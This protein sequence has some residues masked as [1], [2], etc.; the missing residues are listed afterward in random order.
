MPICFLRLFHLQTFI[1]LRVQQETC[2]GVFSRRNNLSGVFTAAFNSEQLLC[3]RFPV[4]QSESSG[5]IWAISKA[6]QTKLLCGAA[7]HPGGPLWTMWETQEHTG[8]QEHT[9]VLNHRNTLGLDQADTVLHG[10]ILDYFLHPELMNVLTSR[11]FVKD[12]IRQ[13]TEH[14]YDP[15]LGVMSHG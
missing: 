5:P 10:R 4:G 13:R 1:K 3:I 9:L 12:V 8:P 7:R 15:G 14:R 2:L 11:I 6:V